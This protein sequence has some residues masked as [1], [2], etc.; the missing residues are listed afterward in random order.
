M[1]IFIIDDNLTLAYILAEWFVFRGHVT[2]YETNPHIVLDM[3]KNGKLDDY[4]YILLDLLLNGVSG[5]DI[6]E[7]LKEREVNEKVIVVSGCDSK[8]EVFQKAMNAGLPILTK[9][10]SAPEMITKLEDGTIREMCNIIVVS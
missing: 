6:Y 3:A 8:T 5:M 1:R 10:F 9:N 4:D 2:D 7:A